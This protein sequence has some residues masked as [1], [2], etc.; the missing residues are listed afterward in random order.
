MLYCE[1]IQCWVLLGVERGVAL[2]DP[3]RIGGDVETR[4]KAEKKGI[5]TDVGMYW[6]AQLILAGP[7]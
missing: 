4:I 7:R 2:T 3:I 6:C 1:K 5:L